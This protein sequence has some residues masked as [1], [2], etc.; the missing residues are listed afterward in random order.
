MGSHTAYERDLPL[1][2][3]G[4]KTRSAYAG[5]IFFQRGI[6]TMF[7]DK[8][9]KCKDCGQDFIFSAGEQEFYQEKGFQNEPTRCPACRKAR[10]NQQPREPRG[11]RE[12][13]DAVCAAC[14]QPTKVPFQPRN[15]KPIYCSACYAA[16]KTR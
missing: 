16:R 10:K 14:G 11:D 8:T 5:S 2:G 6:F 4:A 13:F 15:D 9:L 7:E 3:V 1:A 12:M